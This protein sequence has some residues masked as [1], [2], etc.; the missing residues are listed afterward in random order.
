[1]TNLE[2]ELR[3]VAPFVELPPERDLAPSVR[4]RIGTRRPRPGKL[5][6]ALAL[7]IIAIAIAFAVPPARS[8]ILDW[9]GLGTAR[10]EFVDELPNVPATRQLNLGERTS[11]SKARKAVGYP[12]VTSKLLGNPDQVYLLGDQV[13]LVYGPNK[14]IV[15]QSIGTFFTKEIGRGTRVDQFLMNGQPAL[16]ITG[17][18]H[19]FGYIGGGA[20]T[21]PIEFYLVGNALIWQRGAETFRLEGKLSR[22]QAVRIAKTF[23]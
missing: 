18:P 4:A 9:L 16:W 7:V 23:R 12:V 5:V 19:F 1:M 17:A 3:S 15:T 22:A 11:L 21:H 14:L 2:H 13:A 20:T 10:V 8:E 6:L